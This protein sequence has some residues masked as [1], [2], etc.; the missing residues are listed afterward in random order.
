MR[1]IIH[2]RVH[3][4]RTDTTCGAAVEPLASQGMMNDQTRARYYHGETDE[5]H[6]VRDPELVTCPACLARLAE[7]T[8]E[9]LRR[10]A[11]VIH[12]VEGS[13]QVVLD[14]LPG[15]IDEP[16]SIDITAARRGNRSRHA[17]GLCRTR[18]LP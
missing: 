13:V 14:S 5:A 18:K 6:C 16:V 2:H 17:G 7:Q 8:A 1:D 15:I 11:R 12:A 9:R 3:P 4:I 10:G